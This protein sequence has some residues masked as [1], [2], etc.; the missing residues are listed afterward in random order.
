MHTWRSL[1]WLVTPANVSVAV[2]GKQSKLCRI[3][4]VQMKTMDGG[5]VNRD[6]N[7]LAETS[8][9]SRAAADRF[10]HGKRPAAPAQVNLGTDVPITIYSSALG[11]KR[12]NAEHYGTRPHGST[13][14][15][16]YANFTK[17]VGD[18]TKDPSDE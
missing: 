12:Y 1:H 14:F 18:Y 13:S 16:K 5:P 11:Q 10:V 17:L 15:G 7:F 6:A 9:L 3:G 2:L 4:K 8:C